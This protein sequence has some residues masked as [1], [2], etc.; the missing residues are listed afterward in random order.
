VKE[1]QRQAPHDGI[2]YGVLRYLSETNEVREQLNNQRQAEVSF[3]YAERD[4]VEREG[5][6]G[7]SAPEGC[8]PT[9]SPRASRS[10]MLEVN[11]SESDGEL[12]VHWTYSEGIHRRETIEQLAQQM[13]RAIR[14]I[15]Q[16]TR[17]S[18]TPLFSAADFPAAGLS[19]QELDNLMAI[20]D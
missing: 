7:A 14:E 19:Q 16:E 9:A 4:E 15:I 17:Q 6:L 18:T 8:G 12:L 11:A 10:H 2:G 5:L 3:N 1:Q 13:L 20:L